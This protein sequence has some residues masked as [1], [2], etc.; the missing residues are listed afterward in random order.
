MRPLPLTYGFFSSRCRPQP[1]STPLIPPSFALLQ[2]INVMQQHVAAHHAEM[3]SRKA[4]VDTWRQQTSDE[5]VALQERCARPRPQMLHTVVQ[6]LSF[7]FLPRRLNAQ[8]REAE[9]RY[10]QLEGRLNQQVR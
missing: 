1:V 9:A 5:L 2:A 4:T 8:S 6:H 3:T 7:R 10:R